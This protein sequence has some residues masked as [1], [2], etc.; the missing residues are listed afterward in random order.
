[1]FSINKKAD[2]YRFCKAFITN[3]YARIAP[4]SYCRYTN[5][6]GRGMGQE[7]A[8]ETANYFDLCFSEYI[9]MLNADE[10]IDDGV[11]LEYGPGDIPGVA[12][13][14]YAWG[15]KKVYCVDRFSLISISRFNG[16][17]IEAILNLLPLA[18]RQRASECFNDY[19]KPHSG[20][21]ENH[22]QYVVNKK[23]LSGFKDKVDFVFS[24]AVLEHVNDISATIDDMG[25]ALKQ[26]G[27]TVNKVDLKSHGLHRGNILEF[28]TWPAL[29]WNLMYS[30]KGTPN[31]WRLDEY[32]RILN[33]SHLKVMFIKCVE[34]CS[35]DIIDEVRPF[36]SKQFKQLSDEDLSCLSFWFKAQKP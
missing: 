10:K 26:G 7:T 32:K 27:V 28:L 9:G 1:M 17:V 13:L 14:L 36:L 35:K 22:I 4:G 29:L 11:I 33:H 16:E 30:E 21:N 23:G 5:E 3:Q 6:T 2:A 20:F 25:N 19:G 18:Q 15:A 8:E 12:L 31:R 34:T 24:R